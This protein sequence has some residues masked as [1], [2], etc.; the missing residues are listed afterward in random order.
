[1]DGLPFV[2][3]YMDD[4]LIFSRCLASHKE[5]VRT[6]MDRLRKN[7][8]VYNPQKSKFFQSTINFLGHHITKD[9]IPPI[10]QNMA[11]ISKFVTPVDKTSLRWFLGLLNYYQ[12]W[13]AR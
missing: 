12:A 7:G 13:P 2:Y 5:A 1:M 3:C 4:I 6:V 10:K 8:L 11:R 9:G